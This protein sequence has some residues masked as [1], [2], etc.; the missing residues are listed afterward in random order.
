MSSEKLV[1][2]GFRPPVGAGESLKRSSSPRLV[3]SETLR[4]M[5]LLLVASGL[6][7]SDSE[8]RILLEQVPGLMRTA[9]RKLQQEI[10]EILSESRKH[11][12]TMSSSG[13]QL[14]LI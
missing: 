1:R 3:F 14:S 9:S 7:V 2:E 4:D 8:E 11:G 10:E 6:M 13:Q 5:S 12:S